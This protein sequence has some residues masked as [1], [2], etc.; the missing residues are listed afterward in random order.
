MFDSALLNEI[1]QKFLYLSVKAFQHYKETIKRKNE[2]KEE[3][4]NE[5]KRKNETKKERK[6]D[7]F[8]II[9]FILFR[10]TVKYKSPFPHHLMSLTS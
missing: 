2:T 8:R 4:E 7:I 10:K 3:K 6:K 5:T 1:K 9:T